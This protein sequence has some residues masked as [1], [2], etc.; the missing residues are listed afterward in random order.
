MFTI[1]RSAGKTISFSYRWRTYY[2]GRVDLGIGFIVE[3]R[4]LNIVKTY[5][6]TYW[7]KEW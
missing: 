5:I 7:R 3:N 2:L 1:W 4:D 6:L